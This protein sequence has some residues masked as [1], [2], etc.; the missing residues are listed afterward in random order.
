MLFRSGRSS[1]VVGSGGI[2]ST[3]VGTGGIFSTTSVF[4]PG[5][6]IIG[7]SIGAIGM[8]LV[9]VLRT[10]GVEM[11]GLAFLWVQL[12]DFTTLQRV[13][14]ALRNAVSTAFLAI[15]CWLMNPSAIET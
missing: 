9:K 7:F 15:P 12:L 10:I 1:T 13:R 6:D 8:G 2:A 14:S 3:I 11:W 5:G 4:L